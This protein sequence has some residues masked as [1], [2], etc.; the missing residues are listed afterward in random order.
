MS[1]SEH[2][3]RF[4][5]F[6]TAVP[7]SVERSHIEGVVKRYMGTYATNEYV[8]PDRY[9]NQRITVRLHANPDD[10][11]RKFNRTENVRPIP[12]SDP[13]FARLYP[14]RN[15]SESINRNLEDTLWI[16]RAHSIGHARQLL[17]LLGYA[18]MVNGLALHRHQRRRTQLAA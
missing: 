13:D 7:T 17:N 16:G 14:R 18:L 4:N 6:L 11:S 12:P 15:D 9:D 5:E 2:E 8:L 10:T 1:P 3:T